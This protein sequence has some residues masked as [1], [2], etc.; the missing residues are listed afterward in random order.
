MAVIYTW[1]IIFT[2]A[3]VKKG[4]KA[5]PRKI[6]IQQRNIYVT[7]PHHFWGERGFK[8]ELHEIFCLA[9]TGI[10]ERTITTNFYNINFASL[11]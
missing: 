10:I 11:L 8:K 5:F 3:R 6:T 1:Y 2:K 9:M 4:S 7:P